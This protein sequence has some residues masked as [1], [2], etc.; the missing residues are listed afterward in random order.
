MAL[1][2][3]SSGAPGLGEVGG[4]LLRGCWREDDSIEGVSAR[5]KGKYT[6]RPR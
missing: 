6:T 1:D 3:L 2:V 4:C 5:F